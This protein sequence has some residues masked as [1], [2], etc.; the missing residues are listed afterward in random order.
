MAKNPT[1]LQ[2][3]VAS[4]SDVVEERKIL[5]EVIEE[6]NLT[7]GDTH[8]LRL[9]LVKW[10]THT[11]PGFGEDAQD[12]INEQIGDEYDIFLGIMWG[13]FGSPTNRAESGTEEEFDRAYSRFKKSPGDLQIMFYFKDAGIPPSKMNPEQLTKVQEFK[14]KIASE[15]G[16]LYH[17]F[18]T[19]E[20]FRTKA[21]IHLSNLVQDWKK[22]VPTA[23]AGTKTT[24][25]PAPTPN[26]ADPLAH[27]TALTHDD[28]DEGLI[29]LSERAID[30]MAAVVG[31]V[32]KMAEAIT[33]LGEK[34]QQRTNEINDLIAYGST[35][36]MKSVKR[37]SNN[38][39]NDIEVYVNRMSAEIPEFSK[40]HS[41]AMDTFG[42]IAIISNT[43]LEEEPKDI[44]AVLTQIKD[45]R[46][47]ISST[48][49]SLSEWRENVAG[50]P[51]M[52][53]AF[54]RA[55]KRAIAIS[56]DLV[57]Q[58]R[59]AENQAQDVERLLDRISH[60]TD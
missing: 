42:K 47:A 48:S 25:M 38:A 59:V 24:T 6:F 49:N 17:S 4:P 11:R 22:T 28:S 21:R 60:T 53:T 10:E 46:I 16:G 29:E 35:S 44:L 13:R 18:E 56:D 15:Y 50:M 23:G 26:T 5:E 41:V 9:E 40:Q 31:I 32:E 45:Y 57:A 36:D 55:R 43:D 20:E 52:T 30:T 51:R 12:V 34:F 58:L 3:F 27:L 14:K 19:T 33:E 39:A 7:W 8:N 54:N 37:I 2:V 1:L